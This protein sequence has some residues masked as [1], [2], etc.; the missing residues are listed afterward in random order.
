MAKVI[1]ILPC[2]DIKA[3]AAFYKQLGF[4]VT[5]LY[6]SPNLYAT[7]QLGA[8]ELHF[9]G[10]RKN[11][12]AENSSM[13]FIQVEDV[14]DIYDAFIRC[15]KTHT[16]KIP[17]SGI[18]KISK[19]RDLRYDRRFTL[20][21]PG[22]NTIYIG[23]PKTSSGD[24][25]FRT[26]QHE[27]YATKFAVLYDV[28]YSKEDAFMAANTLSKYDIEKNQL[29][30]LDKAKFLLVVIDIQKTCGQTVDD[31]E[32]KVLLDTYQEKNTDWARIKE[33]Y[34]AILHEI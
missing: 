30:D 28:M 17:R 7:I 4:E 29:H 18:P 3:Q 21:D 27:K 15:F 19:V 13:C 5:G 10:S 32:L 16:G 23:T 6:T 9:W 33:K 26:L 2:G 1:P 12:P 11:I 8:I 20:T 25:F 22:G 31:A 14:D 24:N 34:S